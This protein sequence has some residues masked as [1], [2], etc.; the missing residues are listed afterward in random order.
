VWLLVLAFLA[1]GMGLFGTFILDDYAIFSDPV[2]TWPSGWWEVW[3][4][5][6]TR[7]LTYFTFWLNYQAGGTEPLGYHAINL[8]L[9]LCAVW[10]A[11]QALGV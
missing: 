10:L 3:R 8:V 4:L 7:P 6:Q 9:H 2:L 1:F 5:G 11:F